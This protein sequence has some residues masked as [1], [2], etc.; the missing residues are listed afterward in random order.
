MCGL[1]TSRLGWFRL[2]GARRVPAKFSPHRMGCG[3]PSYA[4]RTVAVPC[5]KTSQRGQC[6]RT[7]LP[8][9][10]AAVFQSVLSL[11]APQ[12]AACGSFMRSAATM[13]QELHNA[14][15]SFAQLAMTSPSET[16]LLSSHQRPRPGHA[17]GVSRWHASTTR[18][19][20]REATLAIARNC[21]M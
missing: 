3:V 18:M 6:S 12:V 16:P 8:S 5:T 19:L 17:S 1:Y 10:S 11:P 7:W 14:L 4:W 9:R 15:A 2:T 20:C 21:S 13:F